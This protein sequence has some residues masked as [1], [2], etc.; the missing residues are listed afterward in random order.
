MIAAP[1]TQ[2]SYASYGD[3]IEARADVRPRRANLGFAERHDFLSQLTSH[4]ADAR[5]NLCVFHCNAMV[6]VGQTSFAVS[7]LERHVHSTQAFLP[8]GGVERYLVVVA[9]GGEA[10]DLATLAAFVATGRQGITYHPG[11]WHHPLVALHPDSDFACLVWEDG[12]EGDCETIKLG[13]AITVTL[14]SP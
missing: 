10:P 7:L 2:A 8:M 11:I 9:R 5:A 3:V 4:R 1:L 13:A 6:P 14:P 12:T